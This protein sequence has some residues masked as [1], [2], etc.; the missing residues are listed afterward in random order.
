MNLKTLAASCALIASA[1]ASWADCGIEAGRVNIIGNEFPA[2]QTIAAEAAECATGGVTIEA[3]LTADHQ[4]LNVAG[5]SGNPAEYTS[6]IVANSSIVALIN[7]DV[8]RPL[9]DLVAEFGADIPQRQKI[10]VGGKVMAIAFMANAQTLAYRSDV[11]EQ[12]GLDVPTTYEE[13]LAAAEAIRAAGIMDHPVGGAY[14]AGWNIAQEFNNMYLGHGGKFFEDGSANVSINNPQGVATLEVMKALTEYMN[15]DYLTHDSNGT[16]AEWEAGNVALMN[17][18]GSRMQNIM[19]DEGSEPQ[20]YENTKVGGP[21]MVGDSGVPASTLWWDGWTVS[22]NISDDDAAATFRSLAHAVSPET[23][24]D[25]TMEQAVWL[26]DGYKPAPVSEGVLAAVKAGTA[27]YPMLPYMGLLHTALGDNVADF[28][29]GK[30]S[31]E[32]TLADIEAAY[33]AA[34]R[35]Q[36]YIK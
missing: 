29:T 8:I 2:I 33:T 34:A 15:P 28:M 16:Q 17:M 22:K 30:E 26:I 4:T 32:Q 36:G 24:T 13:V 7:E 18:W 12:V 6:A 21:L 23:L 20:V 35:E 19:D 10:T 1:G 9:D 3:N 14:A 11:L 27:P 25:D 31:A 5:M